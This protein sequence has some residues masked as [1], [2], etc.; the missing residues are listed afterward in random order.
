M[1]EHAV[2]RGL[3]IEFASIA[4]PRDSLIGVAVVF[5]EFDRHAC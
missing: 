2:D 4:L 1:N 3:R 5:A